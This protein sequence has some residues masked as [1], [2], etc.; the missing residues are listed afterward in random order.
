MLLYHGDNTEVVKKNKMPE[1]LSSVIAMITP[2]ILRLLMENRKLD[3]RAAAELL[4]NS[5]LYKDFI[6]N[7]TLEKGASQCQY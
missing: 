2:G 6:Q 7:N 5:Q 3:L 4:Y 1:N